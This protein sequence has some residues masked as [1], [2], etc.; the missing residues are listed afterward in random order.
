MRAEQPWRTPERCRYA[1]V[2]P[3]NAVAFTERVG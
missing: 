2:P 1:T 3:S